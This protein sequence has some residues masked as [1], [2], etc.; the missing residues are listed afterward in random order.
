MTGLHEASLRRVLRALTGFGL[1]RHA[2]DG[3]FAGEAVAQL[4]P[5]PWL[6]AAYKELPRTVVTG[7]TGTTAMQLARGTPLFEFLGQHPEEGAKFDRIM[8]R[9]HAGEKEAVADA[10][11][12]ATLDTV[13]DVG[14]GNGT[15][16]SVLLSRYPRLRGIVFDLRR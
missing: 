14:G 3:R 5:Y 6:Q 13:V 4:D 1:F 2:D 7:T 15:F 11:D 16:M 10:Y 9:F 12:F 8:T